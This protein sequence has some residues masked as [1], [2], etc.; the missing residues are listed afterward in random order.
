MHGTRVPLLHA[1]VVSIVAAAVVGCGYA[2]ILNLR[3]IPPSLAN[4]GH[5]VEIEVGLPFDERQGTQLLF[6]LYRPIHSD[7]P[8]PLVVAIFGGGWS[9]G[10]RDQLVE[11][12]YDLAAHGYVAA[13]IDYRL[14]DEQTVF[15]SQVADVLA[16]ITYLR[17][18]AESF[19][20]DPDRVATLGFSAGALLALVA[21]L[22]NDA[23]QFDPEYP[24]GHSMEI[25]AVVNFF[26]PT[27]LTVNQSIAANQINTLERFLG[28]D[29]SQSADIRRAASPISYIRADGPAVLTLHGDAD[30]IVPVSQAIRLGE[31]MKSVGQE[32]VLVEIPGMDHMIGAIWISPQAQAFRPILFQFLSDHLCKGV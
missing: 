23:S 18:H 11:Y 15:P 3:S 25:R 21:G 27:D 24:P 16:A 12:A 31:A 4:V 7:G 20:I 8:C 9:T 2:D 19:G 28:R 13:A 26:G 14:A 17:Q 22:S 6:D 5:P 1:L 32:H 10:S 30:S 29:F